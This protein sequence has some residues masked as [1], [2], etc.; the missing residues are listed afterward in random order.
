MYSCG[1][2]H[3]DEQRQDVQ[4]EH[5]YSSSV[6]IQ[7]VA[8][9]TCQ[10]QW[11]IWRGGERGSEISVLMVR[12]DDDDVILICNQHSCR[13]FHWVL[14]KHW[15]LFCPIGFS[16][17]FLYFFLFSKHIASSLISW[18]LWRCPWC[19]GFRRRKWTRRYEFKFHIAL[20][21]FTNPSTRAVLVL[22]EMQ[23]VRSRIWTR[24]AVFI[25]YDD[26]NYTTVTSTN[27]TNTLGEGMNQIILP[28]AMGK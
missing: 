7:D 9:K 24:V 11:T 16:F 23:S 6:P 13:R 20:I 22:C 2:L 26:N 18:R 28:P 27:S 3:G 12:H 15:L 4:L 17:V 5:T 19:N 21:L 14:S 25:S 8:R 10:G 1:P